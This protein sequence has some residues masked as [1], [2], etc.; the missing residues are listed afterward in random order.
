LAEREPGSAGPAELV[1]LMTAA[2]H[3][4][5]G[6]VK[7]VLDAEGIDSLLLTAPGPELGIFGL[8]GM[9]PTVVK[10]R[11]ADL[12]RAREA[13]DRTRQDSVDI[14][15]SEVDTGDPT[16]VTEEERAGRVRRSRGSAAGLL[17]MV[18]A[19]V[20]ALSV[21]WFAGVGLGV[22]FALLLLIFFLNA[23]LFP[24]SRPYEEPERVDQPPGAR[25]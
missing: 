23:R 19:A 22:A 14:D 20:A 10:V 21:V 1:D 7:S 18:A 2:S 5:A 11:R 3:A 4:H 13:L 16:P 15:W 9:L 8:S 6:V 12:Q 24:K 25:G 17:F